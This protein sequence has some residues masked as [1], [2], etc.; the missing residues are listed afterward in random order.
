M[1]V[2]KLDQEVVLEQQAYPTWLVKR[3]LR[4]SWHDLHHGEVRHLVGCVRPQAI[5]STLR[6]QATPTTGGC[7]PS[8]GKRHKGKHHLTLMWGR[9][10]GY[11]IIIKTNHHRHLIL[12]QG[13]LR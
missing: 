8:A 11:G 1:V 2:I 5:L 4:A 7:G 9:T 12:L 3:L 13:A 6:P 10:D